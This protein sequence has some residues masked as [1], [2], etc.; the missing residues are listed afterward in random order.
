[1]YWAP[2][3]GFCAHCRTDHVAVH[4]LQLH[5]RILP[6]QH[7]RLPVEGNDLILDPVL[8]LPPPQIAGRVTE[9]QVQGDH[10]L[11]VFG[12][13]PYAGA[14]PLHNG[15]YMVYRGAQLRFGKLTR[16]ETDLVLIDMDS[17]DPFDFFLDN[18]KE[19]LVAGCT[20]TTPDFG[21]RV[22]MRDFNKVQNSP[23]QRVARSRQP[24]APHRWGISLPA[25][26]MQHQDQTEDVASHTK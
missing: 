23:P 3:C 26:L 8:L 13:K 16:S 6:T 10:I 9:V 18:Y 15:N 25:L 17:Q 22:F 5:G 4:I 21:L 11:Q 1:M 12:T 7:A 2:I 19:Q 14:T 20:K 24:A